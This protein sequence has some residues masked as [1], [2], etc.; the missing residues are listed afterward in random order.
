VSSETVVRELERAVHK[1]SILVKKCLLALKRARKDRSA[2]EP[3]NKLLRRLATTSRRIE[4]IL[5]DRSAIEGLEG[6]ARSDAELLLFYLVEA[7]L[8]EELEAWERALRLRRMGITVLDED[9]IAGEIERV[10]RLRSE[11][12][13]LFEKVKS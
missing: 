4:A 1:H 12:L 11:A 8:N 9:T 3:A 7:S 6:G 2:I 13:N 10:R 5:R